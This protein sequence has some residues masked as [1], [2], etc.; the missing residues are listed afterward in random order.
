MPEITK[1]YMQRPLRRTHQ[2]EH[3]KGL[4]LKIGFWLLLFMT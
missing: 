1:N 3:R 4:L 2:L